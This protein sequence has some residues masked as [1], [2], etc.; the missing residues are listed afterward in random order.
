MCICAH[1]CK[2][3]CVCVHMYVCMQVHACTCVR[4]CMCVHVGHVCMCMCTCVCVR[5]HACTVL[6]C[7]RGGMCAR[8]SF[9]WFPGWLCVVLEGQCHQPGSQET[10][11]PTSG[12][13]CPVVRSRTC[14]AHA[15]CEKVWV[16]S[17]TSEPF[18][19]R[20]P[21]GALLAQ[22]TEQERAPAP[23]ES[24]VRTLVLHTFGACSS[25][26]PRTVAI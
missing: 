3:V 9:F 13:S 15:L 14:R 20:P 11:V 6:V 19:P 24:E 5:V 22:I 17:W 8:A 18:V 21:T 4:I 16:C 2:H 12:P 10:E 7:S 23:P 26:F 1:M 25:L